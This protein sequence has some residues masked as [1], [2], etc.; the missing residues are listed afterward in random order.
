LRHIGPGITVNSEESKLPTTFQ[1]GLSV[2]RP[3]GSS[4]RAIIISVEGRKSRDYGA[5][6]LY[7]AEYMFPSV[8]SLQFGYQSGMDNSD[9]SV[10]ARVARGMYAFSYAY[11]P[12]T[13][14]W[15]DT[16]RLSMDISF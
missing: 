8:A 14:D 3:L 12:Y 4:G 16:H 7:G 2:R 9:I 15:D 6:I 13:N 1:G 11:V 5:N 10:G